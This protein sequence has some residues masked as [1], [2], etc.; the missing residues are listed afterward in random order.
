[1]ARATLHNADEIARKD[2]RIG[3][4]VIIQKAGDIIPEVLQVIEGL[5]PKDSKPYRFP[6]AFQGVPLKRQSGEVAYYVDVAA[7]LEKVDGDQAG[8]SCGTNRY[9]QTKN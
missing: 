2:I 1:M 8:F 3:D 4:T 5:R 7:I 9:S 6:T